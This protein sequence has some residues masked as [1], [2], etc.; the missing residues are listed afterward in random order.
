MNMDI[1]PE[2]SAIDP[3]TSVII[4]GISVP[5]FTVRRAHTTVELRDGESFTI[6]G[7]LTDN[8]Q[9]SIRQLPF[10]GDLPVL[11]ALFRS[12]S[13]Q[14]DQTELVMVVTP[15]IVSPRDAK[16]ATPADQ[17]VPPSDFELFLKGA[18]TGTA[19]DLSP[20]D[21]A[22]MSIDPSKG[23]VDGPYGHVLY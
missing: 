1:N 11:G 19:A 22:L 6:A 2:V 17:F 8:Y 4:S 7:L 13:F 10:V 18:Q 5:G 14:K 12:T 16:V 21:R 20:E 23:G 15:H 3:S 9:N